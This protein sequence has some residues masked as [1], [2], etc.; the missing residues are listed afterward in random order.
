MFVFSQNLKTKQGLFSIVFV[1]VLCAS[2]TSGKQARVSTAAEFAQVFKSGQTADEIILEGNL[3][4]SELTLESNFPVFSGVLKGNGY[5]IKNLKINVTDGGLFTRLKDA[6]V[7]NL[8]F[9]SSCSFEGTDVG[10]LCGKATGKVVVKNVANNAPV[11]GTGRAGGLIGS[12][13]NEGKQSY[14][15]FESCVNK[16]K[17]TGTGSYVSVGGFV[18]FISSNSDM[19]IVIS[20]S[21]N[22]AKV[23]GE[24]QNQATWDKFAGGFIGRIFDNKV[25]TN[26]TISNTINNGDVRG[27]WSYSYVGGFIASIE[28]CP[29]LTLTISNSEMYGDTRGYTLYTSGFIGFLKKNTNM[30]ATISGSAHYGSADGSSTAGFIAK[31]ITHS[32]ISLTISDSTN[33]GSTYGKFATGGFIAYVHDCSSTSINMVNASNDGIVSGGSDGTGG[34]IGMISDC[35]ETNLKISKSINKGSISG[36]I[37]SAGLVGSISY[38]REQTSGT[39]HVTFESTSNAN[40]GDIESRSGVACGLFCIDKSIVNGIEI[41]VANCINKGKINGTK[42]GCGIANTLNSASNVVSMGEL[43]GDSYSF[44]N[45]SAKT[46]H[47]YGLKS[48]CMKCQN[49]VELFEYNS[50]EKLYKMVS[51]SNDV[52][53]L[54]NKQARKKKYDMLWT[55]KLDL[56]EQSSASVFKPFKLFFFVLGIVLSIQTL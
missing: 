23:E 7:E 53:E 22:N 10:A 31:I 50:E 39:R 49:N 25:V 36:L 3:D 37:G 26:V 27:E 38:E 41:K 48:K 40:K 34:L 32:N 29:N 44:W 28:Y 20:N 11:T 8:I 33:K 19:T 51:G 6:T 21:L 1:A 42:G 18:G 30:V 2:L 16:G 45:T 14:V 35:T 52:N 5:S 54:L 46:D 24:A 17:V 56:V 55:T 13:I 43:I 9:E 4:F 12:V 15:S 47:I